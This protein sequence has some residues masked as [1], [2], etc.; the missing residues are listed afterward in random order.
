[1]KNP[2]PSSKRQEMRTQRRKRQRRQRLI[3]FGLIFL[4][5][6]GTVALLVGP[7]IRDSVAP[8][9]DFTIITPEPRPNAEGTRIGDPNAPVRIDVFSDFQC[10]S[11]AIF[12]LNIEP[13]LVDTYIEQGHAYMV[14]RHYPFLDD[15]APTNESDQA[16]NASMCAAEQGRFWDYHDML[17]ANFEGTNQGFF[18]DRRLVAFAEALGLNIGDFESCFNENRYRDQIDADR[19]EGDAIGVTGTPSV[20]VNGQQI[21][22]G[23]IPQFDQ[24]SEAIDAELA[25]Q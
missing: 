6:L 4:I 13:Q 8:V 3:M 9:G 5:A 12:A 20:F 25:N 14:Y 19:A 16:A 17:V 24:L 23:F 15:R 2:R 21:A 22:P 7:T 18:R 11:C 10:S 1:M